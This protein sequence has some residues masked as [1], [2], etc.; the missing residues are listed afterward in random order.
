LANPEQIGNMESCL[1][2]MK[3]LLFQLAKISAPHLKLLSAGKPPL[4]TDL[5]PPLYPAIYFSGM[6]YTQQLR[7]L[8]QV[9]IHEGAAVYP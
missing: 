7:I 6:Q 4:T 9:G 1:L 3:S 5:Q 8:L 2:P